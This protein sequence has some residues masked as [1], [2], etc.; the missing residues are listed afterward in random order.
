MSTSKKPS[1]TGVLSLTAVLVLH[2]NTVTSHYWSSLRL[3]A[4]A[5]F[6]SSFRIRYLMVATLLVLMSTVRPKIAFFQPDLFAKLGSGSNVDNPPLL[7]DA[8]TPP[9]S[10]CRFPPNP[11]L[12]D[13]AF[14]HPSRCQ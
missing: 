11:A 7:A 10:E 12:L 3:L 8:S 14:I 2:S 5:V 9:C 6:V 4:A 1:I 13:L